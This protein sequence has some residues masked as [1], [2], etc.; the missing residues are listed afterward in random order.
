MGDAYPELKAGRDAI[1]KVIRSE[2]ERFD[3]VLTGGLPRLEEALER[4]ANTTKVLS[5]DDAFKLYDTYG[6]PRDFI[7]DL[8][9]NQGLR[10]DAEGFDAAM[11][12]QRE[13]ARAGSAFEGKKGEEFV[14]ASDEARESLRE[15]GDSF[16]GYTSDQRQRHSDAGAVQHPEEG[17]RVVE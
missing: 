16:E 8:A 14:F 7:E 15:A 1:V 13:K 17:R 3:A 4:A 11:E 2:E 12:G 10:F 5:G 9:G 6:L